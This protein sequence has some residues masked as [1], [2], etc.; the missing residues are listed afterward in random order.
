LKGAAAIIEDHQKSI[1]KL[2]S[3]VAYLRENGPGWLQDQYA[4]LRKEN[5]ALKAELAA[6]RKARFSNRKMAATLNRTAGELLARA[7]KAE[8]RVAELK[9][10][11]DELIAAWSLHDS[12]PGDKCD[13]YRMD[14]WLAKKEAP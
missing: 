13:C 2:E 6:E 4:A 1:R 14:Y 3:D 8:A 7:E 5:D 9:R 11:Q 12:N 10:R